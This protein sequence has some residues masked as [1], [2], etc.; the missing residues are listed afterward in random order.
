MTETGGESGFWST[1]YHVFLFWKT[2]RLNV[3]TPRASKES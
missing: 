1:D 3:D 2:V